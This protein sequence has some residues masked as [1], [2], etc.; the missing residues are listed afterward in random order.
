MNPTTGKRYK[1]INAIHLMAQGRSDA[2]WMTYKQAAAEG[3]Q[4][5]KGEKGTPVQ[6]WKFSEEQTKL[7]EQ[8]KP[9]LDGE[10]KPVKESV[11]L[12]RPRVFFA[13]VFNAEQI[14]GLPPIQQTKKTEQQW[15]AVE[16][17]EHILNASGAKIIHAAG[18]RAFYRPST[19]SITMP[20]RGQ[21]ESAD[22]YYATALHELG[23][24]TGHASRLDR[25]LS[26]PF[27]SE[28]Y[29]K[30]ELR[31]EIASMILGDELGIGHDPGQHVAYVGSW[32]KTLQNDPLEVF[33]A[34][35]DAEKIHDYVL[36]FEQKQVQEQTQQQAQQPEAFIDSIGMLRRW[37]TADPMPGDWQGIAKSATDTFFYVGREGEERTFTALKAEDFEQAQQ[38]AAIVE[39]LAVDIREVLN[40]PDVTFSHFEA[41]Q[42]DTLEQALRDRGLTTVGSVVGHESGSFSETAWTR[43]SPVFGITPDH[44]DMGNPYLERKGLAQEFMLKAEQLHQ[45]LQQG[46]EAS[47][48]LPEQ[49]A[50]EQLPAVAEAW[51]L[52]HLERGTLARALD[53][54][55]QDQIEKVSTVLGAMQPLNTQNDFWTRHELPQDVDALESKLQQAGDF[56]ERCGLDAAVAEARTA[57]DY[58]SLDKAANEALGFTLPHDWNGNVQVQG[59][60][61]VMIEGKEHVEPAAALGVEPTFWGVY[62]QL[63]DGRHDW[64]ADFNAQEQAEEL[65]ERLGIIDAN[66]EKNEHEKAA[67]LARV[68]EERVRRDPSSTDEDISAAKEARKAAEATAMLAESETQ[69]RNAERERDERDRQQAAQQQ[70][71]E[72]TYIN[73]PYREKNEAKEL[74]A[75]WDRQQ[76]S[77]YVPGSL[78]AGPFAKWVQGGATAATEGRQEEQKGQQRGEAQTTQQRTY[79]AVPYGE[80][81]A[82]KAA[83]AMWDKAAKSW[84]AGPKADMERLQRWMPDSVR[85]EQGPSMSPREEFAEAMKDMGCVVSGDHP[86]MDGKK[87]RISV[88][89]DKKGEQAGFYVGH[90]DGHPAGYISNNRTGVDMK[91][92]SKGYSLDSTEKAKL[93]AEAAEKLAA[94]AAEQ[95][96]LQEATAERISKQMANLVPATEQTPYMQKKDIQPHPGVLTD[97]EG[98]KTFIPAYDE[99]GKQWTM[100]YIQEDGTKRFAKDSRKEGCFHIVGGDMKSLEAAPALV[101]QEGYATAAT[102]AE[103]LGFSTVAAF[104]IGNLQAV[105]QVLHD[106]FP[107]KPVV[108]F[109]DDDRHQELTLGRNS[110]RIKAQEAAKAV[111]GKAEFPIFAPGEVEY[112]ADLPPITPQIYREHLRASKALETAP[113]ERR[114]ELQKSVLS[115][116]Q[117][118]AIDN[119]KNHSDFNDL[120]TN[121]ILG[122]EG[123]KRQVSAAVAQAVQAAE[124]KAEQKQERVE[125]HEQKQEQRRSGVRMG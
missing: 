37:D 26:N 106:R 13:T 76:Q 36:A 60:V 83:G 28:G 32:I 70:K 66:S 31:A 7:D 89:G 73:V 21:F 19:D 121:S 20:E 56:L 124:R 101:I 48:Q 15:E 93:Q 52:G 123:V 78:D 112:P 11:M 33:R 43:L 51:T 109:G 58:E 71:S 91:W 5:R 16:R 94:R 105:A 18:D 10:G 104:D 57:G 74:G 77:W 75:R 102:N 53:G 117:L 108:I 110:G 81:G 87:H 46:Q 116:D 62:A 95:E 12:E 41:F 50:A 86:I 1:G 34:A 79:L 100:Q 80:R 25:D 9:V 8:G 111:G 64:L 113:E 97:A 96:R 90:L 14:D 122:R 107:D 67:K 69:R 35:A 39:A 103:V 114:G 24:W 85:S 44:E 42:G 115:K 72:R 84:Y 54:A 63:E 92:K 6:Y 38:E 23:H 55:N 40:N 45:A 30:E 27:G 59:N 2:R 65:A 47:M 99:N 29:A 120:A 98:K 68:Q 3:A 22:R 49:Q 118:A 61:T 17:A 4:V 88:E 125:K 119:M 82:A